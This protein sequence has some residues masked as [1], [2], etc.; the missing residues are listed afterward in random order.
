MNQRLK[1]LRAGQAQ[2]KK[3][4]RKSRRGGLDFL[5]I[6]KQKLSAAGVYRDGLFCVARL[7]RHPNRGNRAWRHMRVN[8]V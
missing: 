3:M 5:L 2:E 4:S 1:S 8:G 7:V 6:S